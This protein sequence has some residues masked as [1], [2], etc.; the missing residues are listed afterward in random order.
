MSQSFM[1]QWHL[2]HHRGPY[3]QQGDIACNRAFRQKES[4]VCH[5]GPSG[6]RRVVCHRAFLGGGVKHLA[7]VS[8]KQM[9]K[10]VR[11]YH[12]GPSGNK[13][14]T[15]VRGPF[16]Q[17]GTTHV[18]G[19]FGNRAGQHITDTFLAK[20]GKACHKPFRHTLGGKACHATL[21]AKEG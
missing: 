4:N 21:H 1:A 11:A 12:R 20:G 6:K 9:V 7:R 10:Y 18:T 8:G 5:R 13:R 17:K 2:N 16:R 14:S 3:W 15:H 19:L